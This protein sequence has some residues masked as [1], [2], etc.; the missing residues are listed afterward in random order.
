MENWISLS[1][2]DRKNIFEQT[3]AKFGIPSFAVEKDWWVTHVLRALFDTSFS[4]HLLFK[5]GTSLSKGWNLIERF[6]EDID[7]ALDRTH[8]GENFQN[9]ENRTQV[10][11]LRRKA[12][13]LMRDQFLSEMA[14]LIT[15]RFCWA[16]AEITMQEQP[17]SDADPVIF[18][19][20]FRSLTDPQPYLKSHVVIE[21][22]ARSL[23]EPFEPRTMRS[24]VGNTYPD[25]PFADKGFEIPIALPKRTF[26]EKAFLLHEEFQKP[27]A[28]QNM[29]RLTR[30]FYDLERLMDT[31]HGTEATADSELYRSIVEH[32]RGLMRSG[33]STMKRIGPFQFQSCRPGGSLKQCAPTTPPCARI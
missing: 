21:V 9:V 12:L 22:S 15:S 18:E 24:L 16:D 14:G 8:V 19:V 4:G 11:R 31:V 13:E 28:R 10:G 26:L 20:S 6:S 29:H 2:S 7:L 17:S 32:R 23:M 27:S 25:V 30:H 5:G 3:A 1:A 33:I